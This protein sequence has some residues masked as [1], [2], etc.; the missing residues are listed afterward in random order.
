MK[1]AIAVS[2]LYLLVSILFWLLFWKAG[3]P[4]NWGSFGFG[5]LGWWIAY[6]LRI[7][8]SLVLMKIQGGKQPKGIIYFSGILE[9][10]VRLIILVLTGSAIQKTLSIGQGWAFIEVVFAI[11]NLLALNNLAAKTDEKS[12][13]AKEMLSA[14]GMKMDGS[15][16]WGAFERIFASA[17][18]IGSTLIIAWNPWMV[19][20][21]IPVHTFYNM[22]VTYIMKRSIAYMELASAVFGSVVFILGLLVYLH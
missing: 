7:P 19:L 17:F 21:M 16:F 1:K 10:S 4:M 14:A 11:V 18:H 15:P 6:L 22:A 9:E 13:Q 8:I 2:P 3:Y 5:I 12:M 20:V